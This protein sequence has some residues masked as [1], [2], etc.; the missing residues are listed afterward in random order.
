MACFTLRGPNGDRKIP[1]GETY[2]MEPGEAIIEGLIDWSCGPQGSPGSYDATL[3]LLSEL[4]AKLGK[5]GGDWLR[6][7]FG[8]VAIVL[9]KTHCMSCDVRRIVANAYAALKL[10]RGRLGAILTMAS[11]WRLSM[12][13]PAA[14]ASK[15]KEYVS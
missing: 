3:A 15:L 13:D 12:K 9:G 6:A 7:F 5:H 8:P 2:R 10:K 14:A 4:D 11:L 1:E